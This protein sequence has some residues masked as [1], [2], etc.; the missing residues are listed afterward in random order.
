MNKLI[1]LLTRVEQVFSRWNTPSTQL[2]TL[3]D[4]RLQLRR[5]GPEFTQ[6]PGETD[7]FD[8]PRD[9]SQKARNWNDVEPRFRF[10]LDI[11]L[12]LQ[13]LPILAGQVGVAACERRE[14]RRR[15]PSDY[16]IRYVLLLP[17]GLD[18]VVKTDVSRAFFKAKLAALNAKLAPRSPD[19]SFQQDEILFYDD[20]G[21]DNF[22]DRA[23]AKIN[24][25]MIRLEK[26]A[27]KEL[28]ARNLLKDDAWL[29]KDGS[30][31]SLGRRRRFATRL[32]FGKTR[33]TASFAVASKSTARR[34]QTAS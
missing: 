17:R 15:A 8:A 16:Q 7:V 33:R 22:E 27:V 24:D 9:L 11:P 31:A 18:K 28:A 34:T 10:F 5:T 25:Y 30:A 6:K 26:E 3:G 19:A 1:P 12:G 2:G 32:D 21:V 13:C 29:I 14:K 20:S 4:R 23:V